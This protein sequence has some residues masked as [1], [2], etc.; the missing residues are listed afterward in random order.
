MDQRNLN[1]FCKGNGNRAFVVRRSR[2]VL[3]MGVGYK[4]NTEK[5]QQ[6]AQLNEDHK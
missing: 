1:S 3:C 2:S 5:D 4:H 6:V